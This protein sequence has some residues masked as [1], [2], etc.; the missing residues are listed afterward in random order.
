MKKYLGLDRILSYVKLH[1]VVVKHVEVIGQEQQTHEQE[2]QFS[3]LVY[4]GALLH[5]H[6]VDGMDGEVDKQ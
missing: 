1:D 6:V 4:M 2:C 3:V 5:S